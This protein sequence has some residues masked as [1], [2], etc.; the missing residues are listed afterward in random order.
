E[1]HPWGSTSDDLEHP[2]RFVIDLDPDEAIQWATLVESAQEIRGHLE[3]AGFT[4]FLK[5]TGGKGLHLV[6]PLDRSADWGVVVTLTE[7]VAR[8]LA[9]V[10]PDRYVAEMAKR[11]RTNKIFVDWLRNTRGATAVA[12]YSTRALP[13]A[14]V[15]V[16]LHWDELDPK[17][18]LRS[19]FTVATVPARMESIEDP[20]AGFVDAAAPVTAEAVDAIGSITLRANR[21]A[22]SGRSS[23]RRATR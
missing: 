23:R 18:D 13:T 16:P 22:G 6:C 8:R 3:A 12:P 2:D 1:V 7:L 14:T 15:S 9:E 20:W 10:R 4:V 21:R 11:L 19:R 17:K 5:T